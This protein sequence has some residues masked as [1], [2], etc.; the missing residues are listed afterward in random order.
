VFFEAHA[1]GESFVGGVAAGSAHY[2]Y[3]RARGGTRLVV[4]AVVDVGT[5]RVAGDVSG[6]TLPRPLRARSQPKSFL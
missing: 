5:R 1:L 2:R 4:E 3:V 6:E